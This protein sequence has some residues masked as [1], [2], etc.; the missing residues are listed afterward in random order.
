MLYTF[1]YWTLDGYI[2]QDSIDS[3]EDWDDIAQNMLVIKIPTKWGDE[4]VYVYQRI[5]RPE[6]IKSKYDFDQK[7]AFSI[8]SNW[9]KETGLEIDSDEFRVAFKLRWV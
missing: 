7:L 8:V 1:E 3:L 2:K 6:P 5:N 9:A 4:E